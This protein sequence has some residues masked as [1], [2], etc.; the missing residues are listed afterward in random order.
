MLLFHTVQT[1]K[2]FSG[3]KRSLLEFVRVLHLKK[4]F[5]FSI[6]NAL[7]QEASQCGGSYD[8]HLG[9]QHSVKLQ[10]KVDELHYSPQLA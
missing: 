9:Q 3:F 5:I 8:Q 7:V 4:N 6:R 1:L 10:L 2:P